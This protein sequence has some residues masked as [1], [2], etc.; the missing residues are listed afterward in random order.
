MVKV[1]ATALCVGFVCLLAWIIA[2]SFARNLD[3]PRLDPEHRFGTR[4]RRW[5][6]AMVGFGMAGMAAEFSP[7]DLSWPIAL[8]LAVAG[9][10]AAVWYAGWVDSDDESDPSPET[11]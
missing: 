10:A 8:V 2:R 3:R 1:Y 7:L 9:A 4:G 11:A 6:A 5:V